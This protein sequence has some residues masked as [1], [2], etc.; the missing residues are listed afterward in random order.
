MYFDSDYQCKCK[1]GY[2]LVG[3]ASLGPQSCIERFPTVAS[4]YEK[5]VFKSPEYDFTLDS[6]VYSHHY[7]KSAA[8]C[9]Y[10]QGSSGESLQSC[11]ALGNLCVMSMY[12]EDSA[13]CKQYLKIAELRLGSYHNQEDWKKTLPWLYYS[14]EANDVTNDK[15]IKMKLAFR[16]ENVD[17]SISLSFKLAKY[18][19]DGS[20]V[21]MEDLANQLKYCSDGNGSVDWLSFGKS[22]RLQYSCDITSLAEEDMFFYDMH[23]VDQSLEACQRD[24]NDFECLYPVPILNRNLAEKGAFP[25]MNLSTLD[26]SNDMYTRRFFLFDNQVSNVLAFRLSLSNGLILPTVTLSTVWYN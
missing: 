12:D 6:L 4:G 26:E 14:G 9:E 8:E 3:E 17:F 24:T 22:H 19:L 20:F 10:F 7:V 16:E 2:I 13:A 1:D 15:G 25:N 21:G 23:V 5:A 18:N 11:Q